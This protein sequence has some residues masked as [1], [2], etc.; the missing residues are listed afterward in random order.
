[1][2]HFQSVLL[3]LRMDMARNPG[4]LEAVELDALLAGLAG[5]ADDNLRAAVEFFGLDLEA[6]EER[7]A[8]IEFD[9]GLARVAA[10]RLALTLE[11]RHIMPRMSEAMCRWF[12][13][14]AAVAMAYG[15]ERGMSRDELAD[16]LRAYFRRR[17]MAGTDDMETIHEQAG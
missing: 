14:N 3:E 17:V 2:N 11:L 1:M 9:G 5:E 7:A 12:A 8:I 15:W 4:G 13:Q 6:I 10:N 16:E